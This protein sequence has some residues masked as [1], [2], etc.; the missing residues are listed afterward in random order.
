MVRWLGYT[1]FNLD[2]R[3]ILSIGGYFKSSHA[4]SLTELRSRT[5]NEEY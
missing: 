4:V 5:V 3:T 2:E 1:R